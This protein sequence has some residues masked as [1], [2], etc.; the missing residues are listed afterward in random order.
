MSLGL[1][2]IILLVIILMGGFRDR[3]DGRD[4]CFGHSGLSLLGAVLTVVV[5]VLFGR[6]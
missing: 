5:L 4:F 2:L 3:I 1:I 6:I